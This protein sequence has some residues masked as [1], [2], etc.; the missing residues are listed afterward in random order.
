MAVVQFIESVEYLALG[1]SDIVSRFVFDN[2]QL[3]WRM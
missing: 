3:S 1:L 2:Q